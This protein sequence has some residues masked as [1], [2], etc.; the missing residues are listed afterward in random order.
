MY[1]IYSVIAAG[2]IGLMLGGSIGVLLAA[3]MIVASDEKN[4]GG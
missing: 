4:R 1:S 3:L 2:L